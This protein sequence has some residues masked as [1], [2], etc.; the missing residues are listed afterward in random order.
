M[1]NSL[2]FEKSKYLLVISIFVIWILY[3]PWVARV[4]KSFTFKVWQLSNDIIIFWLMI[5]LLLHKGKTIIITKPFFDLDLSGELFISR[6]KKKR[7]KKPCTMDVL[8]STTMNDAATC[9]KRWRAAGLCESSVSG[10]HHVPNLW[11]V[12]LWQ[13]RVSISY[14]RHTRSSVIIKIIILL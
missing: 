3:T 7:K 2:L 12:I 8:A 13:H 1:I 14:F 6:K 9:D 4:W 11:V 5:V 10:T